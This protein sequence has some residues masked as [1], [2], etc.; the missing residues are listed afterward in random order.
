MDAEGKIEQFES[1][2]A[3]VNCR[4]MCKFLCDAISGECVA[5]ELRGKV[6]AF[7]PVRDE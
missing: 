4:E 7:Q 3:H 5:P 1:G 6:Y 2:P